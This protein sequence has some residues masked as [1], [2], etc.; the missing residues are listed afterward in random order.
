MPNFFLKIG[1]LLSAFALSMTVAWAGD[2]LQEQTEEFFPLARDGAITL[3]SSDGSIRFYGWNEP[4][5]R[6]TA[7][8]R[9]YTASRLCQI[10]VETKAQPASLAVR[11][12]IPNVTGFFA[13]RSGTVDYTVTVPETARLKLKLVNGDVT[14][15]G[16]RGG[17]AD[18]EL[19]NGRITALDCYA[20]V[21]ARS[22]NGVIEVFYE[23][24]EN[25]PAAF[26]CSLRRGRMGARL[27]A[28]A[29]FRV[30]AH[31]ANGQI[32]NDFKFDPPTSVGPGRSLQA[33]TGPDVPVSFVLHTG[34]G[35]I[36]IDAI[37]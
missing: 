30:D 32:H 31:T 25:L 22:V 36:T 14:L 21:Q 23:W 7:L 10:R 26:D 12:I 20:R 9:A 34:G 5:V 8:R 16:L 15:Q 6:L 18:I 35:N 1:I 13:D 37:P 2:P 3:E 24:W 11:T 28:V 27:P 29:R 4:R 19:V 17:S 33:A